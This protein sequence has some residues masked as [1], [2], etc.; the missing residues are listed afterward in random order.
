MTNDMD[1][2][3]ESTDVATVFLDHDLCVRKFTPQIAPVFNLVQHDIGRSIDSFSHHLRRD[4]L[5]QDLRQVLHS[6]QPLEAEV[7]DRQ[8]HW[9]F[10]RILPYRAKKQI[11]GVVL[12]LI[13]INSLKQTQESLALAV[14]HRE[15]FLATLSH[16]LRNPLS[17]LLNAT[18]L[19]ES[20]SA[21]AEAAGL[22]LGVVRRQAR[23]IARLLDD[24]LDVSRITQSKFELRHER[25]DVRSAVEAAIETMRPAASDKGHQLKFEIWPEPLMVNGDPD[26]LR[27]VQVN[28]LDNAIKYSPAGG[29]I[30]LRATREIDT[31]VIRVSDCGD[32]LT[33]ETIG[34]IFEP[35]FQA[36]NASG[37]R[38]GGMGLGLPLVR[39]I[40]EQ[41]G[42]DIQVRS[43]GINQGSEFTIRLPLAPSPD[44]HPDSDGPSLAHRTKSNGHNGNGKPHA[45]K[46][47]LVEDQADNRKMLT[48]WL[49]LKGHSVQN[50]PDGL[51]A[52]ALIEREQPDVALVDIGLP[53][54]D[55]YEVARRI[56]AG[57]SSSEMRLIALTGYGQ[58]ADIEA[59]LQAGFD[60]HLVKPVN[61]DDLDR[62]LAGDGH[63]AKQPSV[64]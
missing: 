36:G 49:Q 15:T 13:D 60:H 29:E 62:L 34:H 4:S 8:G 59:A 7:Q 41:H 33:A 26:R 54:I 52:V 37:H 47:V 50:A 1:S 3:M 21:D 2:L 55:G 28:L 57:K 17:A 64:D 19:L 48:R 35:F 16:E 58:P 5:H 44:E 11:H 27:Q 18:N 31:A 61:P 32:G 10:L 51:A 23:H 63:L 43:D 20:A 40:V 38:L 53:K 14:K 56:R 24:L 42:G 12:T 22:A 9:K 30:C 45:R 46:I 39:L 6:G 25:F